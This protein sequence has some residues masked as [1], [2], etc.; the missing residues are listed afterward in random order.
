MQAERSQVFYS[1]IGLD[2]HYHFENL[3]RSYGEGQRVP[4]TLHART[5]CEVARTAHQKTFQD[6]DEEATYGRCVRLR[7][8]RCFWKSE[9]AFS[10]VQ[11]FEVYDGWHDGMDLLR[12]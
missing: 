5:R 2:L 4:N 7:F 9:R 1:D 3:F 12:L 6:V 10:L 8:R 11:V